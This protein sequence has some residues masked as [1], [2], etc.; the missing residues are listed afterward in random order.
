MDKAEMRLYE[1]EDSYGGTGRKERTDEQVS[2]YLY[3]L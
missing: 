2:I 1:A 3:K